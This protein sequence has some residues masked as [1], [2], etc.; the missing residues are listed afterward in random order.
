MLKIN[1]TLFALQFLVSY[2]S[3]QCAAG[4]QPANSV[5]GEDEVTAP[6]SATATAAS[7][8]AVPQSTISTSAGGAATAATAA[9]PRIDAEM[10]AIMDGASDSNNRSCPTSSLGYACSS[11]HQSLTLHYTYGGPAPDN[12]CTRSTSAGNLTATDTSVHIAAEAA[13][14]GYISVAFPQAAGRVTHLTNSIVLL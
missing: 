8:D 13:V 11:V 9:P 2:R 1:A 14:S 6:L 4:Q 7:K 5:I 12:V 3:Q 10:D